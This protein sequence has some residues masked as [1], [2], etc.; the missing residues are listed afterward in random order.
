MVSMLLLSD[1]VAPLSLPY[2]SSSSASGV[3]RR[4]WLAGSGEASGDASASG[5]CGLVLVEEMQEG[6]ETDLQRVV[7]DLVRAA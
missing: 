5:C 3:M 7:S 1:C 4:R 2:A 6:V